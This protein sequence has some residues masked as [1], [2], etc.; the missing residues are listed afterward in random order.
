MKFTHESSGSN[1]K[2]DK[3]FLFINKYNQL[4][5]LVCTFYYVKSFTIKLKRLR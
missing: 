1:C 5:T 4:Q 2:N 3:W